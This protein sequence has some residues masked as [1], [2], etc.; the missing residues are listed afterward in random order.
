MCITIFISL[1]HPCSVTDVLADGLLG[2]VI[3]VLSD[4]DI[5]TVVTPVITLDF[6]LR[7]SYAVDVLTDLLTNLLGV[8]IVGVVTVIDVDML[9]DENSNGLTAVA[10]P[11]EFTLSPSWKESMSFC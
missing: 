7:V 5:I 9:A 4:M 6:L 8:L 1:L 2:V 3:D 10:T 11:S